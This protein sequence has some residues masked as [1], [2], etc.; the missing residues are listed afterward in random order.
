MSCFILRN[1]IITIQSDSLEQTTI[2]WE[3]ACGVQLY[4]LQSKTASVMSHVHDNM[5]S[6]AQPCKHANI[7]WECICIHQSVPKCIILEVTSLNKLAWD[8]CLFGV[9]SMIVYIFHN[10]Y[11]VTKDLSIIFIVIGLGSPNILT[12][13]TCHVWVSS[14]CP[15]YH[16]CW[17]YAQIMISLWWVTDV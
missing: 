13:L 7:C 10:V 12:I 3:A 11:W 4:L 16:F 14:G 6:E 8:L 15:S 17:Q 9:G 2:Y 1:N 5:R